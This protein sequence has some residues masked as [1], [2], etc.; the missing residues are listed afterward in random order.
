MTRFALTSLALVLAPCAFA[1]DLWLEPSSFHPVV[2]ER[3]AVALR[4]GQNVR[5]E[6]MPRIPP[7]IERFFLNATPVIGAPGAN[8]AG[9]ARVTE[10]GLQ[11]IG[12]QSNAYPVTLEA[13][14]FEDYLKEEGLE[15]IIAARARQK[16]SAAPGRERFYR[17]AKALLDVPGQ[18]AADARLGFTLELV[19]RKNP[20]A[21]QAGDALPLSLTFR[22]KPIA[23]VLVVAMSRTNPAK[24][25]KARTD[26]NGRVSLRIAHGGFW[27]I[28]A[29][30]MEAAPPNAGI[31]WESW[32]ASVTF[33]LRS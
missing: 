15:R 33:D 3:V 5:G 19:P 27:L 24:A 28:K 31:D 12:Y 4:I 1:H 9:I 13:R 14:K 16:Q 11:W 29:V 18:G 17:C 32:W 7:L 6:P 23:N 10:S 30:H 26:A 2:G 8:P 21:L 25:V 22:G 20:Y